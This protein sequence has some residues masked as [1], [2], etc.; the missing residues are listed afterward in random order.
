[1]LGKVHLW[2]GALAFLGAGL[3]GTAF[4]QTD[5]GM[6]I[7]S[8]AAKP[9]ALFPALGLNPERDPRA[10][11]HQEHE[12]VKD[13]GKDLVC[14]CDTCP[15]RNLADCK[16][17]WAQTAQ[18]ALR[19]AVANGL[20]KDQIIAAYRSVFGARGLAQVPDEGAMRLSYLLPYFV[21]GLALIFLIGFGIRTARRGASVER[22]PE[23][24][25]AAQ[26]ESLSAQ[27][28]ALEDED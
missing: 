26:A 15:R 23:A 12:H 25:T 10:L 28:Q 1:M 11:S 5:E 4:G 3:V 19:G 24:P 2:G 13:V 21:A 14:L 18:K 22:L 16:C 8:T 17:S 9:E 6:E 20:S 7:K 27:L